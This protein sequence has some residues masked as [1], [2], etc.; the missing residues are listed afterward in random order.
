VKGLA[1]QRR[2]QELAVERARRRRSP[3]SIG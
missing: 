3:D 1:T 2:L